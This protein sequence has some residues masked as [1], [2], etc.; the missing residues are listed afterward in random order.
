MTVTL[1]QSVAAAFPDATRSGR[2]LEVRCLAG[3]HGRYLTL[4]LPE[5]AATHARL[6]FHPASL[7]GGGLSLAGAADADGERR[8]TLRYDADS[9]RLHLL[10]PDAAAMSAAVI[11]AD[12]WHSVEVAHHPAASALSW[13][14]NGLPAG[15]GALAVGTPA[16]RAAW[17]GG[18]D[19]DPAALGSVYLDEWILA[20]SYVG[21]HFREPRQD[22]AG[23]PA[24]WMVIYNTAD[25][26]SVRWAGHYRDAHGLPQM[27]LLGLYLPTDETISLKQYRQSILDPIESFL[28]RHT[29]EPRWMGLLLGYRVPGFV[30]HPAEDRRLA[31]AD[32]LHT[33]DTDADF[34]FN[35]LTR[36]GVDQ[37][38]TAEQLAGVRFTCRL[39][40]PTLERAR[41]ITDRAVALREAEVAS[42]DVLLIEPDRRPAPQG[43]YP[44]RLLAWAEGDDAQRLR[45]ERD[46]V[47]EA[48]ARPADRPTAFYWGTVRTSVD[49][50]YFGDPS[51]AA[52]GARVFAGQWR[53]DDRAAASLRDPDGGGWIG[54]ALAS[55]YAAAAVSTQNYSDTDIPRAG[56]FFEA[57]RRGWTLAEA[58]LVSKALVRG[59]LYLVGDPLLTVRLPRRGWDLFG[60][61][62]RLDQLNP[63]EPAARLPE[64]VRRFALPA[65][66]RPTAG[67]AARY[68]LRRI[69]AENHDS[70]HADAYRW[71]QTP[72][73]GEAA[74]EGRG[75]TP[76]PT[77]S[78]P[79]RPGWRPRVVDGM[80][81][82]LLLLPTPWRDEVSF[83]LQWLS[84]DGQPPHTI[85]LSPRQRV[86]HHRAPLPVG[87]T[88]FRWRLIAAPG[89]TFDTPWSLPISATP[90]R[91]DFPSVLETY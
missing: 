9:Q 52:P 87:P 44:P 57:L 80:L 58:W 84:D 76:P 36:V 29:D 2:G 30:Q 48:G 55:G 91:D 4:P 77:P 1:L 72:D 7:A 26:D 25:P 33:A 78:W 43:A 53:T 70:A 82:T 75:V 5:S 31:V 60:P 10:G 71:A 18:L 66:L 64:H 8:W 56:V 73:G 46:L 50:A 86:V 62:D 12:R 63:G 49:A 38:P 22:H 3:D 69:E 40:A 42:T 24:R 74:G 15:S 45:L 89:V 28:T 21:P 67:R 39:D 68:L 85:A 51:A 37:R 20:D 35:P 59:G 88:R 17:V 19:K 6:M 65:H 32:L 47:L 79:D 34:R 23:D 13:W 16:C 27:N 11:G 90:R 54:H 61:L 83:G 81:E 41:A 14:I